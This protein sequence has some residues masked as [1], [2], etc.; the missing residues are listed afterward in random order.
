V[1]FEIYQLGEP[2]RGRTL[3]HV[4]LLVG[5]LEE[6][7]GPLGSNEYSCLRSLV[8]PQG[9]EYDP[10]GVLAEV[11]AARDALNRVVRPYCTCD[12]EWIP[13]AHYYG[14]CCFPRMIRP[15]G[16]IV[17]EWHAFRRMDAGLGHLAG[18]RGVLLA[19]A[20]KL[21]LVF[22]TA[23]TLAA[24]DDW[25]ALPRIS[26]RVL[27]WDNGLRADGVRVD[28]PRPFRRRLW[29]ARLARFSQVRVAQAWTSEFDALEEL[30]RESIASATLLVVPAF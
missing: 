9:G 16:Q 19:G 22:A 29:N 8:E 17:Q 20:E 1:A 15:G 24:A 18:E 4:P 28:A 5:A 11:L 21:H 12:P 6:Y 14:I 25:R 23:T 30:A 10:Q 27:E 2:D 26:G 13:C 7:L 3:S